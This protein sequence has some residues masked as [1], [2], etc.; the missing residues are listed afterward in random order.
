MRSLIL[1]NLATEDVKNT[2]HNV[3][4]RSK[5]SDLPTCVDAFLSAN[6]FRPKTCEA[7]KYDLGKF[8]RWFESANGEH[9]DPARVTVRDVADFREHLSRVRRQAVSTTN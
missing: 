7:I 3:L 4:R 6:D 1:C 5:M 9:F 2:G 8:I